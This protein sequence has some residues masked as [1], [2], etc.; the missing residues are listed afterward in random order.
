MECAS[1]RPGTASPDIRLKTSTARLARNRPAG[2]PNC[3]HEARKPR[4]LLWRAHSIDNSTEPP[5]SPPTPMPWIRRRTVSS[6]APQMPI[7]RI[8]GQERHQEGRDAHQHQGDDQRRLAAD[9][10]AVM[11][12]DERAD[13]ARDEADEIDAEGAERRRQRVLVR[14]EQLAEDE[15]GHRAVEEKIVPL[16][17]GAYRRRD[18]GATELASMLVWCERIVD[19]SHRCHCGSLPGCYC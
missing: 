13:R 18:D 5:H 10:V 12:E 1:P 6:T 3:G 15:A 16:D 4:S 19:V 9:A 17:G 8:A 7:D 2:P 14:E 11:A